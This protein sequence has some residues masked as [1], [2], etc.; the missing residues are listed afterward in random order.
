MI[1][2]GLDSG[3]VA[4][5]AMSELAIVYINNCIAKATYA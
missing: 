5:G 2:G 3:V 1:I 4:G